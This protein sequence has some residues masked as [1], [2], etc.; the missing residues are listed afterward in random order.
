MRITAFI[1][2]D[3]LLEKARL[4]RNVQEKILMKKEEWMYMIQDMGNFH[5]FARQ[6]LKQSNLTLTGAQMEM[7]LVI[8]LNGNSLT[9]MV[10][11]ESLGMKKAAVSRLVRGLVERG[12][13]N[14][15]KS[16]EDERRVFLQLTEEGQRQL[17]ANYKEALG[18]FYFLKEK[19]G[20]KEY[21]GLIELVRKADLI[22]K[23]A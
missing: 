19:M 9:P 5:S 18:P 4:Y 20:D 15:T 7:M 21:L 11:G 22:L 10:A 1:S 16:E 2:I 14:K 23:E 8:Y 6:M 13:I 17:D 12:Y 3:I